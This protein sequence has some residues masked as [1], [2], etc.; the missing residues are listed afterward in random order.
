MGD[1]DKKQV[2]F[3]EKN[4]EGDGMKGSEGRKGMVGKGCK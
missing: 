1:E 2:K 3:W 4:E